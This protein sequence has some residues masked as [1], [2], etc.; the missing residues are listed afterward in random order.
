MTRVCLFVGMQEKFK[1]VMS[2]QDFYRVLFSIF[3]SVKDVVYHTFSK[4]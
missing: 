3:V 2:E 4:L 1:N